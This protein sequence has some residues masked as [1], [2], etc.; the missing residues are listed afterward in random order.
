MRQ[1][2]ITKRFIDTVEIPEKGKAVIYKDTET[3][4]FGLKVTPQKIA[5]IID[6]RVGG[7]LIRKVFGQYPPMTVYQARETAIKLLSKISSGTYTPAI[8]SNLTKLTL[9]D[10]YLDMTEVKSLTA[11]TKRNYDSIMNAHLSVWSHTK[12]LDIKRDM[13]IA[14]NKKLSDSMP[15]QA[16]AVMR[17]LRSVFNFAKS[18]YRTNKGANSLFPD[19]PVDIIKEQKQGNKVERRQSHI[20]VS[21]LKSWFDAM[22]KVDTTPKDNHA[23]TRDY[24]LLLLF[25]GLRKMEGASITWDNVDLKKNILTIPDTKNKTTHRLPITPPI[26]ELFNRRKQENKAGKYVFP[27][28]YNKGHI[29]E[30][31]RFIKQVTTL[32]DVSF[33]LHD[34]RRTF[35]T[36]AQYEAGIDFY[37]V[38]RLL[39]H[40]QGDVTFG[41]IVDSCESLRPAMVKISET[42]QKLIA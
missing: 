20:S 19:N 41:Y 12:L 9:K 2:K 11:K 28:H 27:D 18:Q 35:S 6:K 17:L 36:I 29:I 40:A 26:S 23:V 13:V 10:A 24:I 1:V 5:F 8:Y 7:K 34:L 22:Q 37:T 42:I 15:A 3:K 30:T 39:N 16:N 4:G 33:M 32:S 14:L 38:K 25:T 21:E 31:R